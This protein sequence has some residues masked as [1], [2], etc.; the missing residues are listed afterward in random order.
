MSNPETQ[1][2]CSICIAP[3]GDSNICTLECGHSFHYNCA[4]SWNLQNQS[5]PMC[6]THVDISVAEPNIESPTRTRNIRSIIQNSGT[7]GFKVQCKE[8][9]CF[10]EECD[11][12]GER[13]CNCINISTETP[14][15]NRRNPFSTPWENESDSDSDNFKTCHKCF[16]NR[17]ENI[18]NHVMELGTDDS[19]LENRGYTT[20]Y[21][22][23]YCKEIY[24]KYYINNSGNRYPFENYGN[25]YREFVCYEDF[26]SHFDMLRDNEIYQEHWNDLDNTNNLDNTN[27]LTITDIFNNFDEIYQHLF[28]NNTNTDINQRYN[29]TNSENNIRSRNI[30]SINI[31][32][33]ENTQHINL[34]FPNYRQP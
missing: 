32:Q 5:C 24:E 20:I 4:F 19:Y 18:L 23:P 26:I 30:M 8:C 14:F 29:L 31:N 13:F 34:Q 10:L 25:D 21:D 6:R 16:L 9:E 12:C 11:D 3:L 22:D 7:H 33:P 2:N 15:Y 27:D 17:E 1:E 28:E